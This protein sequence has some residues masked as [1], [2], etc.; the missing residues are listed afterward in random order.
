M[1]FR[2]WRTL[3]SVGHF[4]AKEHFHRHPIHKSIQQVSIVFL[5]SPDIVLVSKVFG[6]HLCSFAYMFTTVFEQ[7]QRW[8]V[9]TET[10][11]PVKPNY[12]LVFCKNCCFFFVNSYS[13]AVRRMR[14]VLCILSQSRGD[15]GRITYT[16]IRNSVWQ[17]L[18]TEGQAILLFQSQNNPEMGILLIPLSSNV[19]LLYWLLSYRPE[20]SPFCATLPLHNML[21]GRRGLTS[22]NDICWQRLLTWRAKCCC[23][24]FNVFHLKNFQNLK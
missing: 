7:S 2:K 11:W 24:W 3:S 5:L 18:K 19:R 21:T 23:C 12:Y 6:T 20:I 4:Q 22:M 9:V 13:R 15:K 17:V 1:P 10:M 8:V 14:L 16:N